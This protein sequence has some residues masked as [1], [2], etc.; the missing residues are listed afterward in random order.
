MRASQS[1]YWLLWDG[2]VLVRRFG[3]SKTVR[4]GFLG[5][6]AGLSSGLAVGVTCGTARHT[7]V[8]SAGLCRQAGTCVA[9]QAAL[10]KMTIARHIQRHLTV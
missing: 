2:I 5:V 8:W 10:G 4:K 9:V 7:L 6:A 3:C 1:L